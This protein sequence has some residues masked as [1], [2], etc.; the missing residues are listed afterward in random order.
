MKKFISDIFDVMMLRFESRWLVLTCDMLISA[1][2]SYMTLYIMA[3]VIG[4]SSI[5]SNYGSIILFIVAAVVANC[6]GA[7]LL[8]IHIG[9]LRYST[10]T[11]A[12]RIL[13]AMTFKAI[14][15]AYLP[16][17]LDVQVATS[18]I[19]FCITLDV[20]LG[21]SIQLLFRMVVVLSYRRFI[22]NFNPE[23]GRQE[24]ML[25]Y[26]SGSTPI[27]S[28]NAI[29]EKLQAYKLV[30][31]LKSGKSKHLRIADK[32]V[33]FVDNVKSFIR[34]VESRKVDS[35]L[36]TN[37]SDLRIEKDGIAR[38][39]ERNKIKMMLMPSVN[40][41][42]DGMPLNIN[43]PK[44]KVEDLLGR[45]EIKINMEKIA[46]ELKDRVV[47]VT[48]AAGSIGSELCRQL[49]CFDIRKLI[50]LDCAETPMHDIR[51]EFT[52]KF[53][54]VPIQF[55]VGSIRQYDRLESLLNTE[56]P[57]IIFHAA[58]YKHVPLM[59]DNPSE[60]ILTN[61]NGTR[62]LAN[63][64][65]K[66]GAERFV[67]VST[68]KAV[69]PTNVMGA[70]KRAA[71]IYIQS[72][73]RAINNGNL[74]G[75]T[76][77]IT[78]RFGNVL[79]SNGSVI[80][81]FKKQIERGGPITVTH[82]DIIRYFMTIPEACG[83][84]LEAGTQGEGD[85]I[86][87]FDMGQPVKIVDLAKRM[88]ELAG[89]TLGKDID[90]TFSGLRP[91]EKL[92]EE[93]LACKENVL[94]TFNPKIFRARVREYDFSDVAENINKLISIAK[95]GDKM[96]IVD[97]MKCIIPEFVSKNSEFEVLDEPRQAETQQSNISELSPINFHTT[98]DAKKL[99]AK[100][101]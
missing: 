76:K 88:V 26:L 71:E 91:G 39:C 24:R 68:D 74:K 25:V 6:V 14:A 13:L 94:P 38:Y 29:Y 55:E 33:Y 84:V 61:V 92:Y 22:A 8:R 72:L 60:A 36:F 42:E 21:F 35:I 83:L 65:V 87:V 47:L 18:I 100:A 49:C 90:I 79:G 64:A 34:L 48:G 23:V 45:E 46:D 10:I 52:E 59:E 63:L 30:G 89:L 93:L 95:N 43:I 12:V 97:K 54:N 99:P 78:T 101:L 28:M 67:M 62:N 44:V 85:E 20:L 32:P 53:P 15:Y 69:N 51:L 75:E 58:A 9:L 77:F 50:V 2:V 86:F 16:A 1:V 57:N 81:L 40:I 31:Y 19:V 66:F 56:R 4:G 70:S 96:E 27:T 3:T 17:I 5:L 11:D 98:V 37:N 73:G 41:V 82:P 7:L 80:P